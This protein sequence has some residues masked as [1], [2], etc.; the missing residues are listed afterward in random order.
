MSKRRRLLLIDD[1]KNF[2][3]MAR[4]Y[5]DGEGL[6]VSVAHTSADGVKAC[7]DGDV[8]VVLLDQKLPDGEGRDAL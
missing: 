4:E 5:L 6:Y 7:S 2:S 8:D 1:D 3:E